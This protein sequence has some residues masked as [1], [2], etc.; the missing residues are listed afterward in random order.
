VS[1]RFHSLPLDAA[2]S[3][4]LAAARAKQ[5]GRRFPGSAADALLAVGAAVERRRRLLDGGVLAVTTGQQAGL[6]TGPLYAVHK[7]VTAAALAEALEAAWGTP[8][9]PVFWAAG[10]DHDFTEINWSLVLDA[11][12]KPVRVVLRERDD[13]AP[14]RPAFREL[15]GPD[16]P[17]ALARLAAVLPPS[18]AAEA[19]LAWLGRA[20]QPGASLAEAFAAAM[21]ELLGPLGVV[22]C[23]G[24]HGALKAAA[25]DLLLAALREA[26]ALDAALA[27]E[28]ERLRAA[29]R[30]TPVG[31]GEGLTL[32]MLEG[33]QGRDRLRFVGDGRFAGRR[34][35]ET[36]DLEG[37]ARLLASEPERLSAN[38]LLRP[39]LEAA[40]FPTV[41]YVGG[42]GEMAY[43]EQV[44]PVFARTGAPRP[45]RFPRLA[46]AL[47]EPKV[48]AI[49]GKLGLTPERLM[50]A[51]GDLAHVVAAQAL[52]AGA[53][54]LLEGL[55]AAIEA[56]YADLR[57][58]A[59]AVDPT[60]ERTADG[61]RN[62]ALVG[63]A[64]MERKLAAALRRRGDTALARLARA[65][66]ALLPEGTPQ[67][68][69]VG[70]PSFLARHGRATLDVLMTAARTHVEA[71]LVGVLP[72]P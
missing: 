12:G 13:R 71:G 64:R 67:E 42:P 7:A 39:A 8:V 66:D 34:G 10:D 4:D 36:L 48:D 32:V 59:A 72:Q 41:A 5:A 16:G 14:M 31:A 6:F 2:V 9:V 52:P 49:L 54:R 51:D 1:L 69:A 44:G 21:A 60:L 26:G 20:Y 15:V 62:Q 61:I 11:A 17:R 55:R 45:V 47:I 38:V 37:A 58:E 63:V 23:R 65:R 46:G 56:G 22:V 35:G 68:R 40:L 30:P 53:A 25:G 3:G 29:G 19:T 18:S 24:W 28:A 43:L 27:A 57:R 50:R 33:V 70:V